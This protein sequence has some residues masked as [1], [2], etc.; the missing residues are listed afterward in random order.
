ML[1]VSACAKLIINNWKGKEINKES[2]IRVCL[3]HDMGNI[4]KIKDNPDNDD[5]FLIIRNRYI[6][7]FGLDDHFISLTIKM[8]FFIIDNRRVSS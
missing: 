5:E 3:L 2:I 6:N 8:T 1:R 4:V 7:E